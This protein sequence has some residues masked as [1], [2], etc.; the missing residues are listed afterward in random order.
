MQLEKF[1]LYLVSHFEVWDYFRQ[2]PGEYI[3]IKNNGDDDK[4][5]IYTAEM[6]TD[7]ET[8]PA[9]HSTK[10]LVTCDIAHTVLQ[11]YIKKGYLIP[12]P[13]SYISKVLTTMGQEGLWQ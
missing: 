10:W 5:T 8:G 4:L 9:I 3:L 2:L 6:E 1:N 12:L 7:W 13:K 11:S